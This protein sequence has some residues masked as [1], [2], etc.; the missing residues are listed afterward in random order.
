M[1][2]L[3]LTSA[4][5]GTVVAHAYHVRCTA[6]QLLFV[7][8]TALSLLYRT[9]KSASARLL[10]ASLDRHAAHAAFAYVV[11]VDVPR[12]DPHSACL[13]V[14]PAAVVSVWAA[15]HVWTRWA[16]ELHALLHVVAVLG[17]HG[18]L[19]VL[20]TPPPQFIEAN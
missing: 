7:A 20:H 5:F 2:L 19:R 15:E 3:C 6:Y 14:F 13:A 1:Q 8:V 12:L 10:L 4:L 11:C 17:L 9:R 18:F 16:N